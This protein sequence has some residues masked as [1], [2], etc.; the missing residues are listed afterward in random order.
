GDAVMVFWN[1]P[2]RSTDHAARACRAA[3]AAKA[4]TDALNVRFK[5]EG[6]RPF[7]IRIGVHVGDVIVGNVGSTERMDYTVLGA[8]V[9]LASRLE[10]LNKE[11]G[12]SILVSDAIRE[13]AGP[14]FRFRQLAPVIAKG[15]TTATQVYE[16][17]GM[18]GTGSSEPNEPPAIAIET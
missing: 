3:L 5:A 15:M 6:L 13:R 4:A 8:A 9:N 7:V 2:R 10:G 11:Y 12:T 18:T 1:A 14:A 17:V 16:L